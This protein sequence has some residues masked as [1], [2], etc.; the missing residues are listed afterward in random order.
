MTKV[1]SVFFADSLGRNT[2]I[3]AKGR[4]EITGMVVADQVGGDTDLALS[5]FQQLIGFIHPDFQQ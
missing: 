2:E 3:F 1:S 4:A 5:R